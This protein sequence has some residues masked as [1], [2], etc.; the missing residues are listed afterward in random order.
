MKE[1]YGVVQ[2]LLD[3]LEDQ[4]GPD[5]TNPSIDVVADTTG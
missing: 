4:T 3:V 5:K 2:L 1:S